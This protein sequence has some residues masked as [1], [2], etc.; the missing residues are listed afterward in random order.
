MPN[1]DYNA[2]IVLEFDVDV[3]FVFAAVYIENDAAVSVDVVYM[4]VVAVVVDS[5]VAVVVDSIVVVVVIVVADNA[6]VVVAVVDMVVAVDI[7]IDNIVVVVVVYNV[8]VVVDNAE[9]LDGM[10]VEVLV[11]WSSIILQI[12]FVWVWYS[13]APLMVH[14]VVL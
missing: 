1:H 9:A 8:V 10:V 4:M 3:E 13:K 11:L 12:C 5:M 2:L 14:V 7:D 6:V